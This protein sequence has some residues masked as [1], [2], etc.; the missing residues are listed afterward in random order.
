MKPL[1]EDMDEARRVA[2]ALVSGSWQRQ[3]AARL[4]IGGVYS[5][6]NELRAKAARRSAPG[7]ARSMDSIALALTLAG[8]PVRKEFGPDGGESFLSVR[9]HLEAAL[10]DGNEPGATS[11]VED[12]RLVWS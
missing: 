8:W 12:G 3:V 11:S 7:Y 10:P 2:A 5:P 1:I 4:L 9:F 6:K